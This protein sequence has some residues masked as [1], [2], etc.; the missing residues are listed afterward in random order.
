VLRHFVGLSEAEV[1]DD[2]GVS[3]GTI[4]ST[5]SRALATLRSQLGEDTPAPAPKGGRS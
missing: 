4:K 3:V 5:A 2:L 1:A